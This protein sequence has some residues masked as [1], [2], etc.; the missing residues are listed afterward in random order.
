MNHQQ[1]PYEMVGVKV[2]LKRAD[3][4]KMEGGTWET[5]IIEKAF[6][7]CY[8][9]EWRNEVVVTGR[10]NSQE[11]HLMGI[12][13]FAVQARLIQERGY[14]DDTS[15]KELQEWGQALMG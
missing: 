6:E 3:P 11:K 10:G 8:K 2:W 4:E 13:M 5:E 9:K 12:T 14:M 15:G 7:F 1:H